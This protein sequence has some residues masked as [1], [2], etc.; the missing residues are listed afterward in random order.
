LQTVELALP[1]YK[2]IGFVGT[3]LYECRRK[4]PIYVPTLNALT[5]LAFFTGVGYHT[6]QG[7]G[8]VEVEL[9]D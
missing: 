3:V 7:M 8:T 1:G 4:D 5:R 6:A 2:Q 9:K